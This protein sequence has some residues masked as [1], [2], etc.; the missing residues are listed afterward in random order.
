MK[1]DQKIVFSLERL[2]AAVKISFERLFVR[3]GHAI[4]PHSPKVTFGEDR[5]GRNENFQCLG[6]GKSGASKT[7]YCPGSGERQESQEAYLKFFNADFLLEMLRF[8]VARFL[9]STF[10]QHLVASRFLFFSDRLFSSRAILTWIQ[11]IFVN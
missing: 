9:P 6:S 2:L 8:F 3:F 7:N 11:D 10:L 5:G 4:C 1:G